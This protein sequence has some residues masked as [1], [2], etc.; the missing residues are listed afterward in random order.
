[1]VGSVRPLAML[2]AGLIVVAGCTTD[3][4]TPSGGADVTAAPTAEPAASEASNG[5]GDLGFA[6]IQDSGKIF[7]LTP[8][9]TSARWTNNDIPDMTKWLKA[10]APNMTLENLDAQ[11]GTLQQQQVEQ[12]VTAGAKGII[13]VP[14]ID[15]G[16]MVVG[17]LQAVKDSGVPVVVQQ[18]TNTGSLDGLAIAFDGN[19]ITIDFQ[20]P[21]CAA[22]AKQATEDSQYTRDNPLKVGYLFVQ[23]EAPAIVAINS[24]CREAMKTAIDDGRLKLVCEAPLGDFTAA[25]AQ[26]ATEQCLTSTGNEVDA[27]LFGNDDQGDGVF[28]AIHGQ[29]LDKDV[30]VIG[31]FDATLSGV[32]RV[33]A[34]Q[35]DFT[36]YPNFDAQAKL[37]IQAVLSKINPAVPWPEEINSWYN[38]GLEVPAGTAGAIPAAFPADTFVY[39][40]NVEDTIMKDKLYTKEQLCTDEA[41][42]SAFCQ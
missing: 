11:V 1:M 26:T 40:D 42:A 14:T 25:T 18:H 33:L 31:G 12:A 19:P 24:N 7:Y 38:D 23:A 34:G 30:A 36:I 39:A 8:G 22:L 29:G 9:A 35:Q 27:I 28:A 3:G 4:T 41:A 13:M 37:A 17:M 2:A 6:P 10:M 5:S 21:H 16:A 15:G 20:V 32:K